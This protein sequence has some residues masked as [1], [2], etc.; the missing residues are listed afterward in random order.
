MRPAKSFPTPLKKVR[1][2]RVWLRLFWFF[3]VVAL[4]FVLFGFLSHLPKLMISEIN[5]SGTRV[6]NKEEVSASI[7]EYLDGNTMLF[8]ARGNIFIYSKN[9]LQEF[10]LEK[11]PRIYSVKSVT[12]NGRKINIDLEERQA[13]FNWCGFE[14]PVFDLR[15]DKQKCYFLDQTGFIFDESPFFTPGVY[16][17]FYGAIK[18]DILPI[19]Q[20]LLTKSSV[21]DFAE[22]LSTAENE[23]L[24]FHSVFIK[25]DGQNELLLDIFTTTDD[26][27]KI[28]FN[29]DLGLSDVSAKIISAKKEEGFLEQFDVLSSKLLYI[30]TRFSNR[31]FYKF[32]EI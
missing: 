3:V 21:M 7:N 9:K 13:A 15:F 24:P 27:A 11:F 6:L 12:R 26:Y 23:G 4:I 17:T 28:L 1:R 29:E 18:K 2:N 14:P 20:T 32:K 22:L 8:Y 19:G 10:V 25:E 31:V 5:I 30:D 16:L